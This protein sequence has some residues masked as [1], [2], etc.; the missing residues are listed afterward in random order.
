[1]KA[2]TPLDRESV[3]ATAL[4][5]RLPEYLLD[6]PQSSIYAKFVTERQDTNKM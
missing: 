2:R 3:V 5:Q 6:D 4:R 1:M